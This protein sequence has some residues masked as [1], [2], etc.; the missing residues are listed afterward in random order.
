MYILF[1]LLHGH[2]HELRK[3]ELLKCQRS[4]LPICASL[5]VQT[6]I[7]QALDRFKVSWPNHG[8]RTEGYKSPIDR[9]LDLYQSGQHLVPENLDE[10]AYGVE[11]LPGLLEVEEHSA[12]DIPGHTINAQIDELSQ[13][14]PARYNYDSIHDSYKLL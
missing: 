4:S 12:G 5:C 2:I 14:D 1:K 11:N 7:S 13:I 10:T 3:N 6:E 8:L 9:P